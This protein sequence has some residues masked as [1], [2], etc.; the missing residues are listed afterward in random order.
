ML[1]VSAWVAHAEGA[2]EQ[3]VKLMR[4]AAD[5]EDGSVKHVA[6]ENRLYPMRELLAELLLEIGTGRA[7]AARVRSRAQ[8]EPQPLSGTLRSGARRRGGRRSPKSRDLLRQVCGGQRKSRHRSA[9]DRSCQD[10]FGEEVRRFWIFDGSTL[11]T[12]G[13]GF[14]IEEKIDEASSGLCECVSE[15]RISKCQFRNFTM[16][17]ALCALRSGR[18]EAGEK[19]PRIGY[20]GSTF[21]STQK[22]IFRQVLRDLGYIEGENIHVE[23]HYIE[24]QQDRALGLVADLWKSR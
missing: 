5:R 3:A 15:I 2:R 18:G 12:T 20:V 24:G 10:V 8:G 17:D 1:A 22:E 11:L 6:M 21:A 9:R 14:R 4:A 13:F 19:V 23:Y 7:R 16:G